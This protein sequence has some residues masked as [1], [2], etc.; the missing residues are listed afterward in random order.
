MSQPSSEQRF[1]NRVENY[2][3]YRPSYPPELIALLEREAKLSP[4]STI[5]DIGSGTGI[6]SEL[7]LE[8]GYQ[9]NGVEPN[10]PMR[11]AAE[12]LLSGYPCFRSVDGSAQ[13][14]TL[15]NQSMDLIVSAQAYH[16]FDTPEA[17]AEFRRILKRGGKIAL[18]WNERHLD[19]TPF[20][21]DY[22]AM[23]RKFGT[24][25]A[26]IRHENIGPAS[27]KLLFPDG[28]DTHTFP[29]SQRFDCEGLEGRL[30]SSSYTPAPGRPGHEPMI[31]EL[32]RLFSEHQQDGQVSIDYDARVYLG[33]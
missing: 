18:I 14:T 11:E 21:R 26:E 32:R 16:W 13:A 25:Y 20:L 24:D 4:K 15:A 8:A 31:A 5:A 12:R 17:R 30:L 6:F 7:L 33:G 19:T 10:Q 9:V 2:V 23:L 22:E 29:N 27:L 1:S 28:Y 3:R